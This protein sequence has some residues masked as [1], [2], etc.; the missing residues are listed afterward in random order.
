[1]VSFTHILS[2][3]FLLHVL[4]IVYP[5]NVYVHGDLFS[6]SFSIMH[7]ACLVFTFALVLGFDPTRGL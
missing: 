6:S 4:Y 1:M 2:F 3:W 5:L 7:D